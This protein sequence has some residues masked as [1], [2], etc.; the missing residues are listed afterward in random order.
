MRC[1]T[2]RE[3]ALARQTM[4]VGLP[5]HSRPQEKGPEGRCNLSHICHPNWRIGPFAAAGVSLKCGHPTISTYLY[6]WYGLAKNV[7]FCRPPVNM[8]RTKQLKTLKNMPRTVKLHYQNGLDLKLF[9]V[10]HCCRRGAKWAR[11]E[12]PSFWW[13]FA[14]RTAGVGD[15]KRDL[16]GSM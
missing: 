5:K 10:A 7:V 9:F 4:A 2:L 14:L 13:G 12:S 11:P 15:P 8:N 3:D 6:S 16:A 1:R